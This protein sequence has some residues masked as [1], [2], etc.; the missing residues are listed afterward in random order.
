MDR[1]LAAAVARPVAP[2]ETGA[3]A[4]TVRALRAFAYRDLPGAAGHLDRG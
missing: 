3:L 2:P 4:A 1:L